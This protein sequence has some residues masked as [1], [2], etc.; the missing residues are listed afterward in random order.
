MTFK[1]KSI[2]TEPV[3]KKIFTLN[4]NNTLFGTIITNIFIKICIDI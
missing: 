1:L 4:K 2:I 3:E